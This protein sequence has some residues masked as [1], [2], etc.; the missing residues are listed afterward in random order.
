MGIVKKNSILLVDFTNQVRDRGGVAVRTALL[1]A[2]RSA[3]A[4]F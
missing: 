3:C 2:V 4:R 1:E